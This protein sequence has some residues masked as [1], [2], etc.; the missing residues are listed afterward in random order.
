MFQTDH[1]SFLNIR[2]PDPNAAQFYIPHEP[3]NRSDKPEVSAVKGTYLQTAK[4]AERSPKVIIEGIEYCLLPL[5]KSDLLTR[6]I[7]NYLSNGRELS[8]DEKNECLSQIEKHR[9]K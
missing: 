7:E 4:L 5:V 8:D 9:Y 6:F 3:R 1:G 2:I